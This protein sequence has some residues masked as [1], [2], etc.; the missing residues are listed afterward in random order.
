MRSEL[1][2]E[3][4]GMDV[5]VGGDGQCDSPGFSAKNL[6]YFLMEI[7]TS[8]ILEIEIRDK[9]HVGLSSANMEKEALKN[10]LNR[11]SAVLNIGEVATDA[12]SSIKKLI[13]RYI[14]SSLIV[15]V[16]LSAKV[17]HLGKDCNPRRLSWPA[18]ICSSAY[19]FLTHDAFLHVDSSLNFLLTPF[20]LFRLYF[21]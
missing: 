7:T 8:Y 1:I 5:V 13:G 18:Y 9:R 12:S 4:V 10:A 2:K 16:T 19:N 15:F 14:C 20:L 21:R 6:C 3:L 11:L 17:S